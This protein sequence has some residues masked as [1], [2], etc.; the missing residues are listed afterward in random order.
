MVRVRQRKRDIVES[1]RSGSER[2][3]TSTPGVDLLRGDA[4]F[5]GPKTVQVGDDQLTAEIWTFQR[6]LT[7]RDQ[8]WTLIHVDTAEA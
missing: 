2:R 3:I 8:N 6:N 7:N 5:V 1:F 4:R